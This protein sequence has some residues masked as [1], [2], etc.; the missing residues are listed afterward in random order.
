MNDENSTKHV[1]QGRELIDYLVEKTSSTANA[2]LLQREE[3]RNRRMTILLSILMA[4]GI[5]GAVSAI[6]VLIKC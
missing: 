6:K 4:V 3:R 2:E 5:G 1:L